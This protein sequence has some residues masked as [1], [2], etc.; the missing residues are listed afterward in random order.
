M[1]KQ[2]LP[3]LVLLFSMFIVLSASAQV[4]SVKQTKEGV[5]TGVKDAKIETKENKAAATSGAQDAKSDLKSGTNEVKAGAADVKNEAQQD[6]KEVKSDANEIKQEVKET[7]AEIR[8]T[9]SPAQPQKSKSGFANPVQPAGLAPSNS[10]GGGGNKRIVNEEGIKPSPTH[11][12][13]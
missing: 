10:K 11:N 13:N 3:F 2:T 5:K 7:P 9:E 6:V 12:P 1:K 4:N 8:S